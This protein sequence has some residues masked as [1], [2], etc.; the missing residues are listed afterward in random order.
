MARRA[1]NLLGEIGIKAR[2]QPIRATGKGSGAGIVLWMPGGGFSSLGRKGIPAE[3]VAQK[4]VSE[5]RKFLESETAVDRHLADQ[6]LLPLALATGQSAFTVQQLTQH[7]TTNGRLLR[8]WLNVVVEIN[9]DIG[10]P[11]QV[12]INGVGFSGQ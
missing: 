11:G 1:H 6:L 12:V 4:C 5:L 10:Q 3:A 8:Q 7:T 2:V 9:G